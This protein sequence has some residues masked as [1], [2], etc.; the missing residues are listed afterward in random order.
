MT[1]MFRM[2]VKS[3]YHKAP[4]STVTKIATNMDRNSYNDALSAL[5]RRVS[6]G[7][8]HE[9]HDDN[10]VKSQVTQ[11]VKLIAMLPDSPEGSSSEDSQED[12]VESS[13]ESSQDS[14]V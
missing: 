8:Q 7:S 14:Q 12:E 5:S 9:N 4:T 6:V 2:L 1:M 10:E 3:D 13:T 11:E